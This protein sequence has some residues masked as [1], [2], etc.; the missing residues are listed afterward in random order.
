MLCRLLTEVKPG[1]YVFDMLTPRFCAELLEEIDH[2]E[3]WCAENDLPLIRPNTMNNYGAVLDTFGFQGM[4]HHL[5]QRY[6]SPFAALFYRDV[7]GDSLDSHHGFVVA[8]QPG[9]DV[10]R[11]APDGHLGDAPP[12]RRARSGPGLPGDRWGPVPSPSPR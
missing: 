7:G 5:M 6:V 1:I 4:L 11:V 2:F 8:Y 3:R 9:K 10:S 12:D